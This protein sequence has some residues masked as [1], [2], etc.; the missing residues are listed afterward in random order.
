MSLTDIFQTDVMIS[1]R[2]GEDENWTLNSITSVERENDIIEMLLNKEYANRKIAK[3]DYLNIKI[4]FIDGIYIAIGSIEEVSLN[5]PERVKIKITS[6]DKLEDKREA[7]RY[8]VNLSSLVKGIDV[9]ETDFS[10]VTNISKTGIGILSKGNFSIGANVFVDIFI[11]ESICL[12]LKGVAIRK[13]LKGINLE[14]GLV[15]SPVDEDNEELLDKYIAEL[16]EKERNAE[17]LMK[18]I[19]KSIEEYKK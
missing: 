10:V 8:D 14:Y 6:V 12:R 17:S 15:T 1:I 5:F 3:G 2:Y 16:E 11:S 19:K 13:K 7:T 4:G 9:A 18:K